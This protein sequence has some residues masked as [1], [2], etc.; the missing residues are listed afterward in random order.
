NYFMDFT[1]FRENNL[2]EGWDDDWSGNFQLLAS[3][4]Y[5]ASDYYL[6]SNISYESPLLAVSMIPLVGRYVER[7]RAYLNSLSIAH[8]RIYSELGYGFTCRYFSMALFASFLNIEY[9][10]MGCKFTFEL[11]RRW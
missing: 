9:Q 6:R 4:M 11:F 7:E 3:E 10:R 1:N 2:P 8:S 5:N